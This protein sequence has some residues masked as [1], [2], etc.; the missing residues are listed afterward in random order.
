MPVISV[1]A[2]KYA[3][4]YGNEVREAL[5]TLFWIA[6]INRSAAQDS[7]PAGRSS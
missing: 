2:L 6:V 4:L 7:S 3:L 5:R 1:Y